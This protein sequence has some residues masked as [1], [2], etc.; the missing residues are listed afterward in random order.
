MEPS[1]DQFYTKDIIA[2]KCFKTLL[3]HIN[4]NEYDILLEPSA[5][6]GAFY[7]LLPPSKREGVDL[8]PKFEGIEK[9]NFLTYQPRVKK[10]YLV[11]GNPPFGRI[12]SLAIKFFNKSATFADTI[13]FILPRTFKRV[14][15]QNKLNLYFTLQYNEDLPLQPCCFEPKMTAKCC[16]QI[17]E[18]KKMPRKKIVYAKTHPD[19][20][21]LKH[22]PKDER[23][24][25]T[26]PARYD[27]AL[28]AYGAN[29]GEIVDGDLSHLRPKSWH[30]LKIK[31]KQRRIKKAIQ[32]S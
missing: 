26:P 6:R 18:K 13:A 30:W 20:S 22:G 9:K 23:Q 10:K 27:L 7:K 2:Q 4:I 29:C 8:D 32:N 1:L 15:V 5:G 31:Y 11:I 14:S 3:Q 17:W 21:F 19:F 28:K 16:F 12:S 25:P 24:Q